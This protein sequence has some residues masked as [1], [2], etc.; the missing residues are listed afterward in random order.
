M[1]DSFDLKE[2]LA[3]QLFP[4]TEGRTYAVLDGASVPKLL[5][6]FAEHDPPRICLYRG[7]LGLELAAM[8]PY[9]VELSPDTPF[10]DFVLGGWGDHWGIFI[11]SFGSLTDLRKH[12]RAFLKVRDPA[13]RIL[14]FRYYDPR[15]LRV[16]L[17]TCNSQEAEAIFGPVRRYIA[18]GQEPGMM[19]RF[20]LE[21]GEVKT[22]QLEL[23]V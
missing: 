13:G 2:A 7:E 3:R 11:R 4:Q 16:Y 21:D 20:S 18:E 8:A 19:L 17:P 6:V 22:R 9:L 15:V 23:A 1:S 12:F 10:T 14:Y 5:Q